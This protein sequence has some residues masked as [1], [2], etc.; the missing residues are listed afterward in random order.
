MLG[1]G[2]DDQVRIVVV[3][4][5]GALGAVTR[6]G[7]ARLM[8]PA[9]AG[10][11]VATLVVNLL[12][13]LALGLFL[14]WQDRTHRPEGLLQPFVA[15]GVLGGL[16][17]FST[18]SVEVVDRGSHHASGTAASYLAATVLGGLVVVA[19]GARLGRRGRPS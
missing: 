15:V 7:L 11:P 2:Q 12:G 4:V 1:V 10:F 13:A 17:T 9:A 14:G 16:T 5:G 8:P 6:Y 18:L 19:A 3:A